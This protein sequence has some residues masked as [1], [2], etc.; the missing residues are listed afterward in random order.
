MIPGLDVQ[1]TR[2]FDNFGTGISSLTNN[3][4]YN[5]PG[6]VPFD[7]DNEDLVEEDREG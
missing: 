1:P 2:A 6:S 3:D 4:V 7:I 5:I